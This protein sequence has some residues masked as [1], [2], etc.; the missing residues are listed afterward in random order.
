MGKWLKICK[1]SFGSAKE[2]R[3]GLKIKKIIIEISFFIK[4]ICPKKHKILVDFSFFL[5]K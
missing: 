3:H 4:E 5:H 2:F 1:T